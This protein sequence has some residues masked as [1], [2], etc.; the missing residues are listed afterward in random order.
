MSLDEI[1]LERLTMRELR[2]PFNVSFRH[3]S[4]ERAESSS[5]WIEAVESGGSVG[6]GEG[7]P[8]PYVT[9]ET[10]DSAH[11]FLS[12]YGESIRREVTSLAALRHFVTERAPAIDA[13]PSAWCAIE[14]AVL[15]LLGLRAGTPVEGLLGLPRLSG[16]FQYTAVLGD[17]KPEASHAMARRYFTLGFRDFKVKLSGDTERDREKLVVFGEWSSA[18]VRVRADANNVWPSADEAIEGLRAL[19]FSWFAVE[20]PIRR[21]RYDDLA[22][23]GAALGTRIVLDESLLRRE[24]LALLGDP[25][26]QW[27]VNVRVSKM[28]GILRALDVIDTAST[29]GIGIVVGAQVGETSLLTRAGLTAASAASRAHALVA[30]EG[31]FGTHLLSRDVCDPPLMFGPGGM[32]RATEFPWLDGPGLGTFTSPERP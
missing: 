23:I 13:N 28:G 17:E 2:L 1:R 16:Q 32:L 29:R 26:H 8:R 19:G 11:A 21:D 18:S 15:H 7:C 3:A 20:E 9:G 14:L 12:A 22:R 5:V 25:V 4:A 24:Q 27:I 6:H 10:I 31:A 30:Q